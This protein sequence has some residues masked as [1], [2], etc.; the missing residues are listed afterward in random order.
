MFEFGIYNCEDEN[1]DVYNSDDVLKPLNLL[2]DQGSST[3][4]MINYSRI[5][6]GY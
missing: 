1:V 6:K 4:D 3:K 2:V 5:G